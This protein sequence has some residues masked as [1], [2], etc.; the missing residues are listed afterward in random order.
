MLAWSCALSVAPAPSPVTFAA[1]PAA[2]SLNT[3]RH[4][5]AEQIRTASPEVSLQRIASAFPIRD[6]D[7][8]AHFPAA[9]RLA[10]LE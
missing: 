8:I 10:G 9:L 5:V 2:S 4:R 6:P 7:A 3:S 1:C